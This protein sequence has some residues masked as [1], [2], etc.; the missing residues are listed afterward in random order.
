M[1]QDKERSPEELIY[2]IECYAMDCVKC[3]SKRNFR[4]LQELEHEAVERLGGKI[5]VFE[6]IAN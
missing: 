2:A 4:R 5:E 3:P 1:K 6:R